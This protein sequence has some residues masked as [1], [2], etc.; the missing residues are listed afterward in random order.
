M[1]E[2]VFFRAMVALPF[3]IN[4]IPVSLQIMVSVLLG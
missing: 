3:L 4:E 1:E 2:T